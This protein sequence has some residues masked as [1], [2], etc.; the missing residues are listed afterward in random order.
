MVGQSFGWFIPESCYRSRTIARKCLRTACSRSLHVHVPRECELKTMSVI[1][2]L[3]QKKLLLEKLL[4][5][6]PPILRLS[7]S[8]F[9][10]SERVHSTQPKI[11]FSKST[12]S[13]AIFSQNLNTCQK[14]KVI[15]KG[16]KEIPAKKLRYQKQITFTHHCW[17]TDKGTNCSVGLEWVSAGTIAKLKWLFLISVILHSFV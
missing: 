1:K 7:L 15:K 6:R 14:N 17:R 4:H 11:T 10:S 12:G 16:R 9:Q 5:P 2:N 3:I 8:C 13:A